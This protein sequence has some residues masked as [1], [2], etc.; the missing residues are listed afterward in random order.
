MTAVPRPLISDGPRALCGAVP[1]PQPV[2]DPGLTLGSGCLLICEEHDPVANTGYW[3][4]ALV[5]HREVLRNVLFFVF[6]KF[7]LLWVFVV[8]H[9]FL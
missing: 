5:R 2:E 4:R 7:C 1:A 6:K 8:A 3:M 9:G